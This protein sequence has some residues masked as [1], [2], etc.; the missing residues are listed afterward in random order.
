M[1][2]LFMVLAILRLHTTVKQGATFLFLTPW[3]NHLHRRTRVSVVVHLP[4]TIHVQAR[5]IHVQARTTHAC[6]RRLCRPRQLPLC[7]CGDATR[8]GCCC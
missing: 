7:L 4:N 3:P 2:S 6:T 5:T 8:R 1:E